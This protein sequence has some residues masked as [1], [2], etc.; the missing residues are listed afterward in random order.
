MIFLPGET[1]KS[2]G[3][4]ADQQLEKQTSILLVGNDNPD[5]PRVFVLQQFEK[6]HLLAIGRINPA[7]DNVGDDSG[8]DRLGFHVIL[9]EINQ[10]FLAGEIA[11]ESEQIFQV[12]INDEN[13]EGL[14]KLRH[15]VPG[16]P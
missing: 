1:Q 7:N 3:E 11:S 14:G 8:H 15:V 4:A 6:M 2:L 5:G 13:G 10:K 9:Q 16:Y 12:V